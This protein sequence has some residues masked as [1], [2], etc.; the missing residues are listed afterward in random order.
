[1]GVPAVDRWPVVAFVPPADLAQRV[2]TG[3]CSL[4]GIYEDGGSVLLSDRLDP[5]NDLDARSILLHEL[6]H[7]IQDKTGRFAELSPCRRFLAR[8]QEAYSVENRYRARYQLPP[9]PGYA[10]M[11]QTLNFAGC[12]DLDD[13]AG[14][15]PN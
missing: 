10:F 8:E 5:L 4:N 12:R 14:S 11:V 3:N 7:F 6:V 1:M 15:A 13:D 9:D 2:C